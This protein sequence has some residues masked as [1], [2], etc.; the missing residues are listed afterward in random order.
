MNEGFVVRYSS[1]VFAVLVFAACFLFLTQA[2]I[3]IQP[4]TTTMVLTEY[5]TLTEK[6]IITSYSTLTETSTTT[7]P[8]IT[9]TTTTTLPPATIT[10]K[11]TE[12]LIIPTTITSTTTQTLTIQMTATLTMTKTVVETTT[13]RTTVSLQN[14]S[15]R[16]PTWQELVEFLKEDETDTYI[17]R[18]DEFD[19]SG[20]ALT[21]R[22]HAIRRGF[23]CAYVEVE[24]I[25]E[26]AAHALNAFQTSDKGLVFVDVTGSKNRT[27]YSYDKIAYLKIGERYGIISL[28]AVRWRYIDTSSYRADEFWKPLTYITHPENSTY[29]LTY[30]YYIEWQARVNFLY[31]TI[32]AYNAAVKE[33]NRGSE[34]YSYEQLKEWRSNIDAL[35]AELGALWP[36]MDVVKNIEIYWFAE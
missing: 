8:P 1:V 31:D 19:C 22:D 30:D 26:S 6:Q 4:V 14:I 3:I 24:F 27:D 5:S 20:F 17:Y 33:Y 35:E 23:R 36:P 15:L 34:K 13:L 25:N 29:P 16:D 10:T 9:K 12:T 32:E 21:L 7:L 28:D 2:N 18:A 11:V